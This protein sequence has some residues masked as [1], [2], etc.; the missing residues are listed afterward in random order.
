LF[1]AI[2]IVQADPAQ[3]GLKRNRWSDTMKAVRLVE[4]GKPLEMQNIPAPEV[5]DDDVLIRIKAAGNCHSDVHY[6][7]GRSRVGPLPQTLGHEV[8]GVVEATG[9]RVTHLQVG[10]RVCVHYMLTCGHCGY[11]AQGSEQ[12]CP[13][14]QMI[15]KDRDGGYAEYIAVP[16]RSVVPL[17]DEIPFEQG[18]VLMCS[19][20]TS[21]HALRKTRLAPGETV[22][23]FGAGGLG[24]AAIQLARAMGARDVYAVDINPDK[25]NLAA[26]LGAIP[27]DASSG[28]PDEL[29]HHLTFGR[30]VNVALELVG[31]KQTSEQA[32]RALAIMGRVGLV[33]IGGKPFEVN[34]YR[35]VLGKEVEIIGCSD[36]LL[37]EIPNLLEYARRGQLVLSETMLQTVPLEAAAINRV[38]DALERFGGHVRTVI[39]P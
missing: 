16:A 2:V 34:T 27:I 31:L 12:F 32:V 17:P 38:L 23:V 35:E 4:M 28:D 24:M 20:S 15:G 25:L 9:S 11:C 21:F 33:G 29:L 39:V 8:A 36:H 18:A 10:L 1:L 3:S 26:Q 30:G 13:Q 6:R 7:A 22:A 14:G 37:Q 19:A 5:R